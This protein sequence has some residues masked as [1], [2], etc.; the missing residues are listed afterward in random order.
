MTQDG[1]MAPDLA[2]WGPMRFVFLNYPSDPL[3]EFDFATLWRAPPWL[4]EQPRA[5]DVAPEMGWYPLVTA[6]QLALDMAMPLGVAGFGH[7]YIA[8]DCI[9]AWAALTEPPGWTPAR[10]RRASAPPW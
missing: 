6:F 8:P 2:P 7:Y 3:V 5:P 1:A 9:D 10:G 4:S